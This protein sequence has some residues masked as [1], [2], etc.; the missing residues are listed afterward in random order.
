MTTKVGEAVRF[1][2]HCRNMVELERQVSG[3]VEVFKCKNCWSM[4]MNLD[5]LPL[6]PRR[7]DSDAA[8]SAH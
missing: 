1:C 2:P 6:Q 5:D 4:H 7:R 8:S 3:G